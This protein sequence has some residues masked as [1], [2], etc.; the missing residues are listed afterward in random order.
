MDFPVPKSNYDIIFSEENKDRWFY[1]D[2]ELFLN[3][4]VECDFCGERFEE[5]YKIQDHF[6]KIHFFRIERDCGES[7]EIK[8]VVINKPETDFPT[9]K[10]VPD[11]RDYQ[12]LFCE[13]NKDRWFYEDMEL[14]LNSLFEC[15]I[16]G[17]RFEK[18]SD[19]HSHFN[20]THFRR[21]ECK[22]CGER[23]QKKFEKIQHFSQYHNTRF[24]CML[25]GKMFHQIRR[26]KQ[27][28]SRNHSLKQLTCRFCDKNFQ[29][30]DDLKR[31]EKTHIMEKT[32]QCKIC[33][34]YLKTKTTLKNHQ[35][36]CH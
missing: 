24:E 34:K 12:I 29:R 21:F 14:F 22:I 11:H 36:I 19:I 10:R 17:K 9:P 35:K 8:P 26:L 30:S 20:Q 2:M 1:E 18:K 13:K 3:S 25:C 15:D 33:L 32:L 6:D 28:Q 31:H 16:C 23:F 7:F 27:H 5:K 4:L